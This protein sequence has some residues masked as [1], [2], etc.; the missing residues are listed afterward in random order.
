MIHSQLIVSAPISLIRPYKIQT[1][2]KKKMMKKQQDQEQ[3][4]EQGQGQGQGQ[5]Q[6]QQQEKKK[7]V[8]GSI[9]IVRAL[10]KEEEVIINDIKLM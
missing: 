7:I 8:A 3:V 9:R 4:Q 6:Q 2:D 1:T 10:V 5:G